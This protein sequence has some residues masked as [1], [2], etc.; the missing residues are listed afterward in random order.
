[1]PGS[2]AAFCCPN[3][4]I[5]A[6]YSANKGRLRE[7]FKHLGNMRCLWR[8]PNSHLLGDDFPYRLTELGRAVGQ[9]LRTL[10][11]EQRCRSLQ[12]LQSARLCTRRHQV[13]NSVVCTYPM[14][15]IFLFHPGTLQGTARDQ[16]WQ[17]IDNAQV[18]RR[19]SL[20]GQCDSCGCTHAHDQGIACTS[21][22]LTYAHYCV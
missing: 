1:M 15:Q 8:C 20:L 21:P 14:T 19:L 2:R 10:V 6:V 22:C 12:R 3:A 11:V 18:A 13:Q 9:C 16:S 7:V 5:A 17:A 4:I